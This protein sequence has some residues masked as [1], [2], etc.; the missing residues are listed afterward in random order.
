MTLRT[1]GVV[2]VGGFFFGMTGLA[3]SGPGCGMVKMGWFPGSGAVAG[4]AFA[5]VMPGWAFGFMA[6]GAV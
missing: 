4:S 3:V 2:M 5:S 6:A 1:L